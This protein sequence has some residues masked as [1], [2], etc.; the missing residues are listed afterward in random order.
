MV[1]D[2][3]IPILRAYELRHGRLNLY[4]EK[5]HAPTEVTSVHVHSGSRLR[6]LRYNRAGSGEPTQPWVKMVAMSP[7]QR[8]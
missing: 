6:L 4:T 1:L 5:N 2:G 8:R 3:L 7:T